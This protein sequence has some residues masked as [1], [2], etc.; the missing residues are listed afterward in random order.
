MIPNLF[1]LLRWLH[2]FSFSTL[3]HCELYQKLTM[4][5]HLLLINLSHMVFR[6]P[7]SMLTIYASPLAFVSVV[8]VM[9]LVPKPSQSVFT[10][11]LSFDFRIPFLLCVTLFQCNSISRLSI[12]A[13]I[14]FVDGLG[15]R[16][17]PLEFVF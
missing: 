6:Q 3:I 5:F 4:N 2:G 12:Y 17:D 7:S 13:I 9:A 14:Y 11:I 1:K 8:H 15:H 10:Q 16:F